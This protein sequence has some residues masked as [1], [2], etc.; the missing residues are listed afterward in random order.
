MAEKCTNTS[1]PF[2]RLINPYPLASL[3]HF[4][5]PVSMCCIFLCFELC[6]EIQSQ[7]FAG[8][9]A[10]KQI[11]LTTTSIEQ[12]AALYLTLTIFLKP[13]DMHPVYSQSFQQLTRLPFVRV[14]CRA[15]LRFTLA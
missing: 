8:R 9:S 7:S 3:N 15:L 12:A 14:R 2:C 11:L 5:V 4:T 6:A 10:R 13:R 1:S